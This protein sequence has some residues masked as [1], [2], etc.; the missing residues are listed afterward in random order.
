MEKSGTENNEKA[1]VSSWFK[2]GAE[3]LKGQWPAVAFFVLAII[4]CMLLS[5]GHTSSPKVSI[6]W[7]FAA[8]VCCQASSDFITFSSPKSKSYFT[9]ALRLIS[10]GLAIW[11]AYNI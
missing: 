3:D 5:L 10:G 4:V 2:A 7:L 9:A 11:V 1:D 6:A 8:I